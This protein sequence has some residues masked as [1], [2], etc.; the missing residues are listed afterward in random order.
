M[1]KSYANTLFYT[2]SPHSLH[3]PPGWPLNPHFLSVCIYCPHSANILLIFYCL[4]L[5]HVPSLILWNMNSLVVAF[6]QMWSRTSLQK[7]SPFAKILDSCLIPLCLLDLISN[8]SAN[9]VDSTFKIYPEFITPYYPH[10]SHR[11]LIP[12]YFIHL[13][14]GLLL[15]VLLPIAFSQHSS[16]SDPLN[17]GLCWKWLHITLFPPSPP[18]AF[19]N[20]NYNSAGL[21]G[22]RNE[23]P[24]LCSQTR[25]KWF[26]ES[27]SVKGKRKW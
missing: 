12:A 14:T 23:R 6:I 3:L 5:H 15:P 18:P 16:H 21:I 25:V 7:F 13:L 20:A 22:L 17:T 26:R 2:L 4:T 1:S 19:Y 27:W 10:C 24:G 11:Y 9:P 8:P